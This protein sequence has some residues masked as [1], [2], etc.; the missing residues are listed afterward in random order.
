MPD[1]F[2][3]DA[4]VFIQAARRYYAF[5][6]A[7]KF[8][9]SLVAHA[10][11]G[12][13]QS[14]DRVKQELERGNDV[15]SEWV[16]AHFGHAFASTDETDIFQSFSEIMIWVNGQSQFSDAAKSNFATIADGWLVAYAKVKSCILVTHEL[17]D[18]NIRRKIPIPN[19]CQTFNV[20]FID[21]F[22]MLRT[23]GVR[24]A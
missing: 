11:N 13:V 19:V 1:V 20:Q 21:T 14:I 17:L 15:L 12:R 3:L 16:K 18:P 23:L 5:D 22:E 4:N 24:F 10:E 2:I 9:D 7:P 6:L 8:W